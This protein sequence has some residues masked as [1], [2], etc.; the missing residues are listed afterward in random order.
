MP[1]KRPSLKNVVV[2]PEFLDK[3]IRKCFSLANQL[4]RLRTTYRKSTQ[5]FFGLTSAIISFVISPSI[6]IHLVEPIANKFGINLATHFRFEVSG[7]ITDA[8]VGGIVYLLIRSVIPFF[9]I[10]QRAIA[11][12]TMGLVAASVAPKAIHDFLA[13]YLSHG[14][15]PAAERIRI[16]CISGESLFGAE[17]TEGTRLLRDWSSRGRLDVIMPVSTASNPTI[18]ERYDRYS[19]KVKAERYPHVEDLVREIDKGKLYLR[20]TGNTVTEHNIL[21]M[22]RVV[23]LQN[24]CLVQNYYPNI[25]GKTSDF[26]PTFVYQNTG[27]DSYYQTYL[28]MF[29]LIKKHP[30]L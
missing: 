3:L 8:V 23:I 29:D 4:H 11:T 6:D 13:W 5:V 27:N 16:I 28:E 17:D 15:H 10:G 1:V 24:F 7:R 30:G 20:K 12:Y 21:C 2:P 9:L 22:W 26:A 19:K 18:S 25:C 14:N